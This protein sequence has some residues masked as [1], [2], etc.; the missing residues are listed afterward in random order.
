[1]WGAGDWGKNALGPAQFSLPQ[2]ST[3][4][5]AV[6]ESSCLA[7]R[8]RTAAVL[9]ASTA[10]Q[11]Q[12]HMKLLRSDTTAPNQVPLHR[13]RETEARPEPALR[14]LETKPGLF[15]SNLV[16]SPRSTSAQQYPSS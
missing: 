8:A 14:E 3:P 11:V 5:L 15:S 16:S 9:P 6:P 13:G 1:M 2:E 7:P 10:P 12:P 4:T